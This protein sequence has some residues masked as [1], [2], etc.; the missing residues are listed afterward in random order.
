MGDVILT[1]IIGYILGN[2]NFAYILGKL[3]K[4]T[5]IRNYG[6]GNAGATNALRVFGVKMGLTTFLLDCAKGAVAVI[7]GKYILGDIGALI[8][9]ISVVVGHNWPVVLKFKG[10]KGIATTI[11]V[12]LSINY[13]LALI[14]IVIGIILI[15]KTRYVSLGSVTGMALLPIVTLI[16]ERPID[17]NFLIFVLILSAFAIFRHKGN[18]QRLLAGTERKLGEKA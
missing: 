5:D 1:I 14:C 12:V 4:N 7:I 18:I 8:G 9:G 17:V 3:V 6:S 10:G 15:A 2:L 13:I 11:G 16:I